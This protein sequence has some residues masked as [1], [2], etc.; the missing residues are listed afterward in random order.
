MPHTITWNASYESAPT[1]TENLSNGANRVRNLKRDI[2][3]RMEL[4][5][6]MN[7]TD[8]DGN[9]K[10]STYVETPDPAAEAGKIHLYA[11]QS[12]AAVA[13]LFTREEGGEIRQVTDHGRL[14]GSQMVLHND[15][16]LLGVTTGGDERNLARINGSDEVVIGAL[17]QVLRLNSNGTTLLNGSALETDLHDISVAFDEGHLQFTNRLTF[18]WKRFTQWNGLSGTVQGAYN[19]IST[20][21]VDI[22]TAPNVIALIPVINGAAF[23]GIGPNL[24][25]Y[26]G[27]VI[28]WQYQNVSLLA[29]NVTY[30]ML[31]VCTPP[32][33]I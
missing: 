7:E 16:A 30:T 3:E 14:G 33:L 18:L 5:H 1:D 29:S 21:G 28:T 24:I 26:S 9:H 25:S 23:D 10:K 27:G 32:S 17:N 15:E 22:G 12:S 8:S 20:H 4:D 31:T 6:V 19:T 11:K 13:D 2:R